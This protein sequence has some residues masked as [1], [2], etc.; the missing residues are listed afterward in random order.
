[1]TRHKADAIIHVTIMVLK[2]TFALKYSLTTITLFNGY[3]AIKSSW[4]HF[5]LVKK[6]T[7]NSHKLLA[8]VCNANGLNHQSLLGSG[9]E[10]RHPGECTNLARQRGDRADQ[11]SVTQQGKNSKANSSGKGKA[12]YPCFKKTAYQLISV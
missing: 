6:K 12:F 10:T 1:M 2:I 3:L 4:A 11:L 7:T 5:P 9:L 8:F